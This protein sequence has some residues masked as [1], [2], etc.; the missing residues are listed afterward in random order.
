MLSIVKSSV[1]RIFM[2]QLNMRQN[3]VNIILSL[4]LFPNPI[5][6]V[7]NG[8]RKCL[9]AL[10]GWFVGCKQCSFFIDNPNR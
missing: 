8:K 1:L 7:E 10:C 9:I 4:S 6:H 3:I 5:H 2:L